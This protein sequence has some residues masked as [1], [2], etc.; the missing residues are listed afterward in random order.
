MANNIIKR[1][2]VASEEIDITIESLEKKGYMQLPDAGDTP[3]KIVIDSKR[4]QF[5][6]VNQ[7]CFENNAAIIT[8]YHKEEVFLLTK[9]DLKKI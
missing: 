9:D 4:Q 5:W 8:N 6:K 1:F 2:F 3:T 7:N